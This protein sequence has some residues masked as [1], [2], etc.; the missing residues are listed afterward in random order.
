[1]TLP[2]GTL[3]HSSSPATTNHTP[4]AKVTAN[5]DRTAKRGTLIAMILASGVVFLDG[6]VV[7]VALPAIGRELAVGLSSLQ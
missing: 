3:P 4:L 5:V 6:T 2:H 1:M 7:S